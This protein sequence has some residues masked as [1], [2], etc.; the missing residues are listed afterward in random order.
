VFVKPSAEALVGE[1]GNAERT[2][3]GFLHG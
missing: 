3:A 2:R 1:N